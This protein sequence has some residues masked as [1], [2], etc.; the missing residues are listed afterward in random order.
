M[1]AACDSPFQKRMTGGHV[2]Y[3]VRRCEVLSWMSYRLQK[4]GFDLQSSIE[5]IGS[6][7]SIDAHTAQVFR[8]TTKLTHGIEDGGSFS[9]SSKNGRTCASS[10][11]RTVAITALRLEVLVF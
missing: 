9:M 5:T 1:V 8:G 11:R 4:K 3:I 10:I 7:V 2:H 6:L